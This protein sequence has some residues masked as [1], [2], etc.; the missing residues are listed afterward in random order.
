[1]NHSSFLVNVPASAT[2]TNATDGV[3]VFVRFT[4]PTASDR[5][6][7]PVGTVADVARWTACHNYEPF[8][9]LPK[10]GTDLGAV[11]LATQYLLCE[12]TD[13]TVTLLVPLPDNGCHTRLHGDGVGGLTLVV[14][15][16]D[17]QTVADAVTGLFVAHGP[18]P[19]VLLEESAKSVAAHLKMGKLRKEKETPGFVHGFGWCTWDAFY[20]DV[21]HDKVREG[22]ESFQT[23]GITPSYLILDDGWQ[24]VGERK[25]LTAFAANPKFPGDLAPTV[26]MAKEEFAIET[27]LVWHA[28]G[29]YWAGV[30]ADALPDYGVEDLP[31]RYSEA[32]S[33][34]APDLLKW[35]EPDS[36]VVPP[37]HVHRFYQDYHRH[38]RLQ[39]VDGVKIDNQASLEGSSEG[40]GGRVRMMQ[41]YHEALEGSAQVHLGGNVINC[42]S[43]ASEML[44]GALASNLTR[45]STDFWP[46]KPESHGLHLYT[47]A[48]VSAWFGQ[49]V[50]PDWDMFQSGHAAG[51]YHAAGR[52]V[53]GSPVYVSD[54]P[55]AHD[56]NVLRKLVS[57]DSSPV[58][59]GG[60]VFLADRP[61]IPTRDCLFHD[62]TQEDVLLKIW[63][64]VGWRHGIIGAFH[65]RHGE[66]VGPITGQVSPSDIPTM[67]FERYAVYA[68]HRDELRVLTRDEAWEFTLDPLTAEV[69]TVTY[70]DDLRRLAAIGTRDLFNSSGVIEE[71]IYTEQGGQ[72]RVVHR[73]PL[74]VWCETEP[75][76]VTSLGETP[77]PYT[78]DAA[79]GRLDI[80]LLAID[81]YTP[82]FV[83]VRLPKSSENQPA[84]GQ[85]I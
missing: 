47:N 32:V 83:E 70:V 80:D 67:N 33:H 76:S 48:Q 74:V 38:L 41:A 68:H 54:K 46:N 16:G 15:T 77:I 82:I 45:T 11:P 3:G 17:T 75:E 20:Q 19:F 65:A 84:A 71:D 35:F 1:M 25:R 69:F 78:Y 39:G 18:E 60:D 49:F 57:M 40:R 52:A 36:G 66:G 14:E 23:L 79:T 2:V 7:T 51:M 56:A 10:A 59:D 21:S 5:W 85:S 44:Y 43:C 62:P 9:L 73:G 27:F 61:G 29:G 6:E 28:I 24:S 42:M 34:Y 64:T 81:E 8:W 4:N 58:G 50:A 63:N 30:D 26:R 12:H 53:G 37:D 72:I 31:R 22:L 13:G 55:G